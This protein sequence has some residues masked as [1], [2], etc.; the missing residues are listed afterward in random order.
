MV[1]PGDKE[2]CVVYAVEQYSVSHSRAC[3]LFSHARGS[4]YYRKVMPQKDEVVKSAIVS[5]M[6]TKRR[7]RKKVIAMVQRKQPELSASKI[8]RV[9]E[10]QGFSLYKKLCKR[11][12]MN[13]ANAA[14]VPLKANEEWAIDFMHDSLISG[15]KIR[16]LNIIDPYNRF[17]KGMFI[18]HSIPAKRLITMLEIAIEEYGKPKA[19]RTDNGPE[20]I[21]KRFQLWL[22]NN[23]IK[24][25]K[26][27]KGS[28]QENCFI[29]RF[30]RT[31]REE[32]FSANIFYSINQA[33]ELAE[34]FVRE[35]NSERPHESLNNQTP[36]EY[37]A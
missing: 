5:V 4:R 33:K 13:P 28:P 19:M 20:F 32:L 29:E 3:K 15:R 11:R 31:A 24:W 27:Q 35:Y 18:N 12:F 17:C 36:L 23:N 9:Y 2:E 7:G 37:A 22:H 26:I 14:S 25:E 8:R 21:S 10:Q 16:A 1:R 30:N 34:E 6:G